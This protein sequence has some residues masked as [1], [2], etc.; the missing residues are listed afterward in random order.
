MNHSLPVRKI[1]FLAANPT[2]TG[3]LRLDEEIREIE[4]G[5]KRSPGRETF[6]LVAKWAIRIKDLRR[7]LL[8]HQPHIVHFSGH[9]AG[10]NGLVLENEVGQATF[11]KAE[12]L[13]RYFRLCPSVKCVLLN[14]CYSQVQAD[15]IATHVPY[16]IGMNQAIGDNTAIQFAVGFYDALGHQRSVPDAYEWGI[17]AIDAEPIVIQRNIAAYPESLNPQAIDPVTPILITSL[18]KKN[19]NKS[20]VFL[21]KQDYRNRQALLNKVRNYWISGV[22]EHSLHNQTP[23]ELE[24]EQQLEFADP[25]N[26]ST[27][28]LEKPRIRISVGVQAIDSFDELGE[29]RTLLILGNPGS[30]K[31]IILLQLA[32]ELISRAEQDVN[33]LLPVIFNLSSWHSKQ[34]IL[35]WLVEELNTKYQVPKRV[36]QAWIEKRQL[37]FLLDGLDE[38]P[39]DYRE[40]CVTEINAFE[41]LYSAEMVVCCRI[42]AY[43]MLSKHLNFHSAVYICPLTLDQVYQ[44]INSQNSEIGELKALIERDK[45]LQELAQSPLLLNIIAF[46][47]DEKSLGDLSNLNQLAEYRKYL[48]DTYIQHML[49]RRGISTDYSVEQTLRWLIWLAKQMLRKSE[50]VFRIEEL[51][52]DW[53][54]VHYANALYISITLVIFCSIAGLSH[55]LVGWIAHGHLFGIAGAISVSL[56]GSLLFSLDKWKIKSVETLEWSWRNTKKHLVSGLSIGIMG[57]FIFGLFIWLSAHET[58]GFSVGISSGLIAGIIISFSSGLGGS[59]ITTRSF[60]NQGI[61][62]SAAHAAIFVLIGGLFGAVASGLFGWFYQ[63]VGLEGKMLGLVGK[64]IDGL[65]IGM[66]AGLV[67]GGG[68]ACLQHFTLRLLLF[69]NGCLSWN[70]AKFLNYATELTFLQK[71]G[72]GYIFMHRSLMEHFA[73]MDI[74]EK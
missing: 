20:T 16:V 51:Q 74:A 71:V 52:I 43:K 11:I 25:F 2:D 34:T 12:T 63:L 19:E 5:L 30:G 4:E 45:T 7:A 42:R 10:D 32:R 49:R 28:L 27:Q 13:K 59:K 57:G 24:L 15:A 72:G 40:Q 8:E 41:Q 61:W 39:T 53:L 1:L 29:G 48:L 9:G 67:G 46:S 55:G 26:M 47:Y 65:S 17:T 58:K 54:Q 64:I 44:Y 22:L 35:D 62:R 38:I 66:I 68:K 69:C 37:F 18:A 6:E 60:P 31:T 3:R 73:Q 36:G 14:A 21:N 33:N 56:V 23:I 70:Y 50:S